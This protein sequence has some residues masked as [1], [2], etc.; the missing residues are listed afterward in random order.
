MG[1]HAPRF[2]V[3]DFWLSL[4]K[5]AQLHHL[6]TW[7]TK[8]FQNS[9][10]ARTPL[11]LRPTSVF[12]LFL[13]RPN[14]CALCYVLGPAVHHVGAPDRSTFYPDSKIATIET[15]LNRSSRLLY[16][17]SHSSHLTKSLGCGDPGLSNPLIL[18]RA[19]G[20]GLKPEAGGAIP[21]LI[22]IQVSIASLSKPYL[23]ARARR[24]DLDP[25]DRFRLYL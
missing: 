3:D 15:P 20:E 24:P 14:A 16:S 1:L 2:F 5:W 12:P 9:L 13:S 6:K 21:I 10:L 11:Y 4:V 25:F 22:D 23:S 19:A 7:H 17:F 18:C 8:L